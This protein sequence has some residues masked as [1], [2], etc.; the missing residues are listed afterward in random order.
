[1]SQTKDNHCFVKHGVNHFLF[2]N[3]LYS[4]CTPTL[5]LKSKKSKSLN[6][7][8]VQLLVMT[9]MSNGMC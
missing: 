5:Y 3:I 1:M 7:A 6:Q 2:I 9:F 4:Q 8:S